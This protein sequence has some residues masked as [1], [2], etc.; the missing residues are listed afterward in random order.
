MVS[1]CSEF[2]NAGTDTTSTALQWTMANL[3]KYPE[4]QGRLRLAW[5]LTNGIA[6]L[7]E[8][9]EHCLFD[10]DAHVN[11][12]SATPESEARPQR[13]HSPTSTLK[14][15]DLRHRLNRKLFKIPHAGLIKEIHELKDVVNTLQ[16]KLD[17]AVARPSTY[18]S[19]LDPGDLRLRLTSRSSYSRKYRSAADSNFDPKENGEEH[20]TR[21]GSCYHRDPSVEDSTNSSPAQATEAETLRRSIHRKRTPE[22]RSQEWDS[23]KV[24]PRYHSPERSRPRDESRYSL[25]KAIEKAKLP[26]N[27]RM[28]QC[29]PY[30]RT[31]I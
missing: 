23:W 8:G 7:P 27:F 24:V 19:H 5:W 17:M 20:M 22:S 13:N 25:S 14:N 4:T 9:P 11:V 26:P 18:H 2:L 28:P 6:R 3:V 30:D 29:D 21:S 16:Q 10:Y 15:G 12:T 31:G 1:L